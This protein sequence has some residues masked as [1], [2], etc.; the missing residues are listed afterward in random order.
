[1]TDRTGWLRLIRGAELAELRA[2]RAELTALRQTL[3]IERQA[4]QHTADFLI[5]A[6]TT[7]ELLGKERDAARDDLAHALGE[8][9]TLRDQQLLDTEDRAAL[10]ALLRTARRQ[11]QRTDRVYV[12][13]RF[14]RLHSVHTSQDEAEAAAESAGADRAG[15][16]SGEPGAALPPA[17]EVPWRI[18][19]LRVGGPR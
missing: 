4:V 18:Q 5:R 1:M 17:C 13:L 2:D 15:W 10:R 16:M 14:G 9:E 7:V 19:Q 12:L 6:E 11:E 3:A 8:L